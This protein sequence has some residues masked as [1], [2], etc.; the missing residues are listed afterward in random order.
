MYR[1]ATGCNRNRAHTAPLGRTRQSES[2]EPKV[3]LRSEANFFLCFHQNLETEAKF[4]LTFPGE[5]YIKRA[6]GCNTIPQIAGMSHLATV[7]KRGAVQASGC[8]AMQPDATRF[9]DCGDCAFDPHTSA[10]RPRT[11]S[12][13]TKRSQFRPLFSTNARNGSRIPLGFQAMYHRATRC[14]TV[15]QVTRMFHPPRPTLVP[16]AN[17]SPCNRVQHIL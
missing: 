8:I 14:N 2:V 7:S 4:R 5:M 1:H 17:V 12:Q 11:Q 13:I 6:T 10:G 16:A 3:R 15:F 9:Q